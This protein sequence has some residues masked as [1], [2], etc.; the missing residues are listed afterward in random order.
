M[1]LIDRSFAPALL[2]R[3]AA[4]I[5]PIWLY[6]LFLTHATTVGAITSLALAAVDT[7]LWNLRCR[8]PGFRST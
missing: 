5:E 3:E 1:P 8:G 6:L 7:A 2:G 4:E